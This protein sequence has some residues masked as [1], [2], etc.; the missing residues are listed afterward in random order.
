MVP[1]H[2]GLS[3]N[4][5]AG[6]VARGSRWS[7]LGAPVSK[8]QAAETRQWGMG[9]AH[10]VGP[11]LSGSR[12]GTSHPGEQLG[13]SHRDSVDTTRLCTGHSTLLDEYRH[14]IGQQNDPTCLECG[15]EAEPLV[16]LLNYWPAWGSL[17][18]RVFRRDC[19]Q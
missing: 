5:M 7:P 16:H 18:R 6:G 9:G 10:P 1:G 15:D 14:R 12:L 8:G 11:L 19:R 2:A 17:R 13:L 3:G 4:E